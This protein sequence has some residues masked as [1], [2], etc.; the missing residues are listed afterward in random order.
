MKKIIAFLGI[1]IAIGL[2]D[3]FSASLGIDASLNAC[4][5]QARNDGSYSATSQKVSVYTESGHPKGS[6][7]VYL[8][9][10]KKYINFQNAWICIQGKSRFGHNGNWYVIK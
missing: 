2:A 10:G 3:N 8:H 4:M 6:F 1:A 7:T 5:A 9:H